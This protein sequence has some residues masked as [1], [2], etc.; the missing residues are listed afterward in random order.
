MKLDVA[1][2]LPQESESVG[3]IRRV[4][5][6]ALSTF[7]VTEASVDDVALALSEACTNVVDHA[8]D[9]DEYEVRVLM[10][11]D[12]LTI[13]VK[14]TSGEVDAASLEGKL[15][16]ET[17]VDGRGVAIMRA[18]MDRVDF[19]SERESGTIVR[20]QKRLEADP[21]GPLARLSGRI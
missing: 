3:V 8:A 12:L 18:L 1:V 19:M 11:D 5:T 17:S 2:C 10:V 21:D 20:L 9:D 13:S 7:G 14:N 4:I 16:D 6:G 15:P